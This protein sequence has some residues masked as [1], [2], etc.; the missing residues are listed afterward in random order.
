M[1]TFQ[2]MA[3]TS[4]AIPKSPSTLLRK[5][6]INE[7]TREVLANVL[8]FMQ[9]EARLFKEHSELLIP[10]DQARK[11]MLAA[12]KITP[13]AYQQVFGRKE[14]A[15]NKSPDVVN[16]VLK[17]QRKAPK[18]DVPVWQMEFIRRIVHEFYVTEQTR[19]TIK[20]MYSFYYSYNSNC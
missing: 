19:P 1:F 18:S 2:R 16:P 12:T 13:Y 5:F 15:Y 10:L 3:S 4:G 9:E 8:E 6:P 14:G 7:Q 20:G 11:R 17:R